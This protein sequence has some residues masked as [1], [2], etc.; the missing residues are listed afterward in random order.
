[1]LNSKPPFPRVKSRFTMNTAQRLEKVGIQIQGLKES[2]VCMHLSMTESPVQHVDCLF[3]HSI[4]FSAV[5]VHI[6]FK[7]LHLK[8]DCVK[9]IRICVKFHSYSA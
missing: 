9:Q 6:F 7:L 2:D 1:M 3:A 4:K 8:D 5:A